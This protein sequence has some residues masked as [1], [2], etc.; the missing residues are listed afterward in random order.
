MKS[1]AEEYY[2]LGVAYGKLGYWNEAIEAYKHVTH[3]KPD[4]AMA[5]YYL[6]VAYYGLE[7]HTEAIEAYRHLILK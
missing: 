1:G 4:F 6:G 3:I 7:R 5:H 2:N